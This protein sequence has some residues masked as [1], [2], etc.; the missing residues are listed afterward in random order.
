MASALRSLGPV[1]G[2]S[3]TSPRM[4]L[5][6]RAGMGQP[7][8]VRPAPT[9]PLAEENELIW[10]DGTKHPEPYIDNHAPH[11]TKWQALGQLGLGLGFFATLGGVAMWWNTKVEA[12]WTEREVLPVANGRPAHDSS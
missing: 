2:R 6:L 5:P 9:Q 7:L 3:I 4:V 11:L 8:T 10:D 1:L 12:P